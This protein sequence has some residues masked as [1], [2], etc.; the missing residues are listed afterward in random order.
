MRLNKQG[1]TLVELMIAAG[2]FSV[3]LL[4]AAAALTQISR[5]YYKGIISS[6]TQSVSRSVIDDISRS[7]QFTAAD[8]IYIPPTDLTDP[9]SRGVLCINTDRYT[10]KINDQL[11]GGNTFVMWKDSTIAGT[12]DPNMEPDPRKDDGAELIDNRMRLAE[13]SVV[14][15]KINNLYDIN[16]KVV[17]GDDDLLNNL[18]KPDISC[19]GSITGA[20]WCAV[21]GLKT[22]VYKR[23]QN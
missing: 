3:I 11:V 22:K 14:D 10:F 4:G 15:S 2:V 5:L 19:N 12:C 23:I 1:F 21:S 7:L 20:Q 18:G 16:I 17:Y 8:P 13:F 9:K 6:R